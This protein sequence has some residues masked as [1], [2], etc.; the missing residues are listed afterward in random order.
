MAT[1]DELMKYIEKV[2]S[3]INKHLLTEHKDLDKTVINFDNHIKWHKENNIRSYMTM[4]LLAM[5]FLSTIW[6]KIGAFLK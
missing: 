3:K 2:D 5:T 6:D 1:N 4:I